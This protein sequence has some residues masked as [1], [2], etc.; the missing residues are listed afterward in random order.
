MSF[1]RRD[2]VSIK[3]EELVEF[4]KKEPTIEEISFQE[5]VV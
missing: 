3:Q 4:K 1:I 2:T 5:D